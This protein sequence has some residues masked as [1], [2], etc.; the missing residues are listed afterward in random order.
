MITFVIVV[1]CECYYSLSLE[2]GIE[3]ETLDV[4]SGD[5]PS[6]LS[7]LDT[8]L[9]RLRLSSSCP[10]R[11]IGRRDFSTGVDRWQLSVH[12]AKLSSFCEGLP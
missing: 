8:Y 2:A 12:H 9:V 7:G 10:R 3:L 4:R 11:D 5:L 6:K 1:S